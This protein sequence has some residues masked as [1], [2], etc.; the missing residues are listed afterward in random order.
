[1][2]FLDAVLGALKSFMAWV[3]VQIWKII[4]AGLKLV[5]Q[6][7][8]WAST[9]VPYPKTGSPGSG[10]SMPAFQP[11]QAK[12]LWKNLAEIYQIQASTQFTVQGMVFF[13]IL[14]AGVAYGFGR[15]ADV[16]F[17]DTLY[18]QNVTPG[19]VFWW[20][21]FAIFWWPI[22]TMIGMFGQILTNAFLCF[23][24]GGLNA[25][26]AGPS[27]PGLSC[28]SP[29]GSFFGGGVGVKLMTSS[30]DMITNAL[31]SNPSFF[32]AALA[33]L[34][35]IFAF[36]YLIAAAFVWV[37]KVWLM[38]IMFIAM[39]I[40]FAIRPFKV[41]P[42]LGF[43]GVM[44][45]KFFSAWAIF[46]FMGV[47]AAILASIGVLVTQAFKKGVCDITGASGVQD[48]TTVSNNIGSGSGFNGNKY[49]SNPLSSVQEVTS[50]ATDSGPVLISKTS[51]GIGVV[52]NP[53]LVQSTTTCQNSASQQLI[54]ILGGL[55][56]PMIVALGPWLVALVA[57]Y[58]GVGGASAISDPLGVTD[59]MTD[60]LSPDTMKDRAG[61]AKEYGEKGI[62][63]SRKARAGFSERNT[64]EFLKENYDW[65]DDKLEDESMLSAR[66]GSGTREGGKAAKRGAGK[67]SDAAFDAEKAVHRVRDEGYGNFA[68]RKGVETT[69][70]MKDVKQK[71]TFGNAVGA[72]ESAMGMEYDSEDDS[73]PNSR[74]EAAKANHLGIGEDEEYDNFNDFL[75][76]KARENSWT[77]S[78]ISYA[79]RRQQVADDPHRFGEMD[80]GEVAEQEDIG[81]EEIRD[82]SDAGVLEEVSGFEDNGELSEIFEDKF[83]IS[84]Q[85][86]EAQTLQAA[87]AG[88]IEEGASKGELEGFVENTVDGYGKDRLLDEIDNKVVTDDN[89]NVQD[90]GDVASLVTETLN[91]VEKE[92]G[93][94][95]TDR[96]TVAGRMTELASN[97][98]SMD[99][100]NE[101]IEN[102]TRGGA[103]E[104]LKSVVDERVET[105]DGNI[106]NSESLEDNISRDLATVGD[107]YGAYDADT[108][109]MKQK[110][111]EE[112]KTP[113]EN[114]LG[115]DREHAD[116]A[117][118]VDDKVDMDEIDEELRGK[119]EFNTGQAYKKNYSNQM[120]ALLEETSDGSGSLSASDIQGDEDMRK[121]LEAARQLG[122]TSDV[123]EQVIESIVEG[124]DEKTKQVSEDMTQAGIEA[125]GSNQEEVVENVGRQVENAVDEA[126]VEETGENIADKI[127]NSLHAQLETAGEDESISISKL[128]GDVEDD[129]EIS[130]NV[131]IEKEISEE[132]ENV[133]EDLNL[134]VDVSEETEITSGD[135]EG[136]D[137]NTDKKKVEIDASS[138]LDTDDVSDDLEKLEDSISEGLESL[139][140]SGD[141]KSKEINAEI[142]AENQFDTQEIVDAIN[143]NGTIDEDQISDE[144]AEV[145]AEAQSL[146]EI[147]GER[148]TRKIK[149][150]TS[151]DESGINEI[152]ENISG[153]IGE[154]L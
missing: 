147:V 86:D 57:A 143:E 103:T 132:I 112:T 135:G 28:T 99:T 116:K 40:M 10:N 67:A 72:A 100:V 15:M 152:S 41:L 126:M 25:I 46:V 76:S 20:F 113:N 33:V 127:T 62:D 19:Q 85:D 44:G 1:M 7:V 141:V 104:A 74:R 110:Y 122:N 11:G 56:V 63:E 78:A 142:V 53:E 96:G 129:L 54:T 91:E 8:G 106:V 133:S 95:T 118:F 109:A 21:F 27:S 131:D 48:T 102:N 13:T 140:E 88:L 146:N 39:P 77:G 23:G 117:E 114:Y 6:L 45:E 49:V 81:L 150:E 52:Q 32:V 89:G 43:L 22:G 36:F 98:A 31:S 14:M 51:E 153:E 94:Y 125:F 148:G 68:K 50:A 18:S 70:A 124:V 111:A 136:V 16:S 12:G 105:D 92:R 58:M 4:A 65:D 26:G 29:D 134:G 119:S 84:T 80:A 2:G 35:G 107:K 145:L 97:G 128:V 24:I 149:E 75:G 71:A 64:D 59:K 87:M 9:A 34:I 121:R 115:E 120:A 93:A 83:Q 73:L 3:T 144:F 69:S 17:S 79:E 5:M 60:S 151:L 123:D 101:F 42:G 130:D 154:T 139:A 66:L 138:D 47:P 37:A 61:K 38:Y 82:L 90:Y 137:I 108:G 30:I 55:M